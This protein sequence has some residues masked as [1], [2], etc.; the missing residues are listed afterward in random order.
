MD[1][2]V[3][4]GAAS[5]LTAGGAVHAQ[6]LSD[7]QRHLGQEAGRRGFSGVAL[8]AKGPK[9]LAQGAWGLADRSLAVPCAPDMAFRIASITKLFTAVLVMQLL[10]EG[11]IELDKPIG[12]YLANY[13]GEGRDRVL[14]R[15][16]LNHT[17]G[18]A[19]F[20]TIG[21]FEQAVR[22]GMPAYQLPHESA[23]LMDLYASG[24]LRSQP[25]STFDYNNADYVILGKILEAIENR[26]FEDI[27]RRRILVPLK[28]TR[29]GLLQQ[30]VIWPR[31]AATYYKDGD[32]PLINDMPVYPQNWYAAGGMAS[33]AADLL[34]F[35]NALYGGGLL[36]ADPLKALLTP[37][38]DE[39][40]FGLWVS[41][42]KV[43]DG[44]RRFAQ[45]PGRIMGA[46]TL[47]LRMLDDDVTVILL[48]NTNEVDTD[49]FGFSLARRALGAPSPRG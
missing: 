22:E 19:N 26:P 5:A 3:F 47:L 49:A 37:G 7:L 27:L 34:V 25:G 24:P 11:R 35:A 30:S 15:Q 33:T 16:L 10:T 29:T 21:S 9:V 39:Y 13:R 41:D 18:I 20:D 36:A 1:R 42:M 40:G 23:A 2:R 43:G 38:L 4:L 6:P 44:R 12:A 28:L 8:V 32:K 45:R 48:A 14:V 17:S 46:N 31:L